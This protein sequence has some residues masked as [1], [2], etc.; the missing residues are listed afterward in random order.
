[1]EKEK[2]IEEK[3]REAAII[4]TVVMMMMA[5]SMLNPMM[6]MVMMGKTTTVFIFNNKAGHFCPALLFLC[7]TQEL[8]LHY[9]DHF[10]Y[11]GYLPGG[12]VVKAGIYP[13]NGLLFNGGLG[14]PGFSFV[15]RRAQA[16]EVGF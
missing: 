3:A 6:M 7:Q 8:F 14:W 5:V 4:T 12:A 9:P 11:F 2:E 13:A 1:M 16:A 15:R 10:L